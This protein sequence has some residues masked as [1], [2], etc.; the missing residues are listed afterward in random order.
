[1]FKEHGLAV[2]ITKSTLVGLLESL[3]GADISSYIGH[4]DVYAEVGLSKLIRS[5]LRFRC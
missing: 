3:L 1:M 4:L 2:T 5:L